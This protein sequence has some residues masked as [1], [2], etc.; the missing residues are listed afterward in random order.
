M[1]EYIVDWLIVNVFL[2]S[3]HGTKVS[4]MRDVLSENKLCLK[5]NEVYR[6][7]V[8]CYQEISVKNLY[9]DAL[10]DE[11]LKKYLPTPEQLSG[12]LPER[13]FF[14]SVLCTLRNQYM[15]DIIAEAHK[16]RYTVSEEDPKKQGI[17]ISDSWL[18]E[19]EKH[20]YHSSKTWLIILVEKPGTGIFLM[21][22]SSK[23]YR[24]HKERE[25]RKLGKRL[26]GP[27]MSAAEA[28]A[29]TM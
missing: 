26:G 20:P 9:D 8:P 3:M 6:M 28:K 4:F 12:R 17:A 5:Q 24:P 23:L 1:I 16:A 27:T 25:P 2:P 14:F 10:K 29:S 22:E 7:E 21:K 11:V 18:A 19:L 13:D 15:R